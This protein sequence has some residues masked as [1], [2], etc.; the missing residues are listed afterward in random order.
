[1]FIFKIL[2]LIGDITKS[3]KISTSEFKLFVATAQK[4]SDYFEVTD[5]RD[6]AVSLYVTSIQ[7]SKIVY[8]KDEDFEDMILGNRGNKN[9]YIFKVISIG[10]KND[11]KFFIKLKKK[12][13]K[14]R[15][16]NV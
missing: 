2:L 16:N 1:M 12:F 8:I 15:K 6:T 10:H 11:N 14:R 4:W 5:P 13:L 3:Y 7:Y 9:S